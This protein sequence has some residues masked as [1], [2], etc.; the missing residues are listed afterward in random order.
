MTQR[1]FTLTSFLLCLYKQTKITTLNRHQVN[2]KKKKEISWGKVVR[3]AVL[4]YLSDWETVLIF[5][6][7]PCWEDWGSTDWNWC[8][9][10]CKDYLWW[11]KACGQQ[12][13][14]WLKWWSN[15]KVYKL[16]LII[17]MYFTG[18]ESHQYSRPRWKNKQI[19]YLWNSS[20]WNS[21]LL[22]IYAW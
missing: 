9:G 19:I 18:I 13:A 1:I 2:K 20:I 12:T 15:N 6:S 14:T 3:I 21:S 4:S 10:S 16:T 22:K 17:C 8:R 5:L 7:L 11:E